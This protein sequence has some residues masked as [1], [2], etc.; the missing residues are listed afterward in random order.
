MLTPPHWPCLTTPCELWLDASVS[1]KPSHPRGHP[2]CWASL[3]RSHTVFSMLCHGAWTPAPLSAHLCIEWECTAS[4]IA[5]TAQLIWQSKVRHSGRITNEMRSV[6]RDVILD[7]GTYPPGMTLPKTECVRLKRPVVSDVSALNTQM[8]YGPFCGLWGWR[9]G[10]YRWPCCPP[11]PI[12]RPT[13]RVHGL[14]AL[15][16]EKIECLLNTCPEIYCGQTV[17]LKNWLKRCRS[18]QV[19]SQS[20]HLR[21]GSLWTFPVNRCS[22]TGLANFL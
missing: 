4:Q 19:R 6:W 7:I 17:D 10:T 14:T 11:C 20:R 3:Q 2:A 13:Y 16:N 21:L 5:T 22:N 12:R 9:R 1:R 8:D 15:D 18:D